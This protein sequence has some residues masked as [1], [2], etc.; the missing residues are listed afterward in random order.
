MCLTGYHDNSL[1][2]THALGHITCPSARVAV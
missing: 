2:A 1:V